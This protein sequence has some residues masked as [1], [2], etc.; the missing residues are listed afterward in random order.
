MQLS[1]EYGTSRIKRE[2]NDALA[3][4]FP[5]NNLVSVE[6]S[7]VEPFFG[8][9]FLQKGI[10]AVV[11][12]ML[13]FWYMSGSPSVKSAVC[14]GVTALAALFH[15]LLVVFFTCVIARIPIGDTFAVALS[16]HC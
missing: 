1:G 11:L 2:L 7:L 14:H 3:A 5:D 12:A 9:Q 13:S 6:T 16:T 15:D 8:K 4:E 10:L